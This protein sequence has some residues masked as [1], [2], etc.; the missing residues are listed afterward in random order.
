MKT[1]IINK[2]HRL[3]V[4]CKT[5]MENAIQF[6]FLTSPFKNT[7][8]IILLLLL[9]SLNAQAQYPCNTFVKQVDGIGTTE[10]RIFK[11]PSISNYYITAT[12]NDTIFIS[13]VNASGTVLST[14]IV[15]IS[16]DFV[17]VTDMIIDR[18]DGTLAAIVRGNNANYMFRYNYG[19][20]SL[21][22][23]QKYT[24]S[25]IFLNI[26]QLSTTGNYIVTGEVL[27]GGHT[28]FQVN[29][30]TGAMIT[31]QK[32]GF[33]GDF[34]SA[35]DGNDIYGACRYYSSGSLFNPS[36][37]R[38]DPS[39]GNNIWT[40]TYIVNP[41]STTCRIY[42]VAP[43][44][45]QTDVVQLSSGDDVTFNTYQTGPTNAWLLKTD[46]A[47]TLAWTNQITIPGYTQLN[48]KKILN[49]ANGYYLLIDSY[50]GGTGVLDYFFVIMTD[51]NGNLQWCN[52]YGIT[53]INSVIGGIEDNGY[54]LLT[55]VSGSFAPG[56]NLVFLKL[57]PNGMSDVNC[58][59]IRQMSCNIQPYNNTQAPKP[60]PMV[61][62]GY[63]NSPMGAPLY[64]T[65]PIE[66]IYC[67]TSCTSILPCSTLTG[68]LASGVMAFWPFGNGSLLDL[69]GNGHTLNNSTFAY[70][71]GDRSGNTNCAYHFTRANPDFLDISSASGTAFLNSITTSAFSIS[72]W[73]QPT[74]STRGVGD[75]ELLIGRGATPLHCPDTWG[76][77]SVGL[78]DCRKAVVGFDQYSHWQGSTYP[79]CN[80]QMAAFTNS[81]HHLAFT[82]DGVSTYNLYIDGTLY[83]TSSGPCGS[84]SANIGP[85]KLGEDYDGDLDDVIIYN[86]AI[87]AAEVT[88]LMAL[89]GS[90]CDGVS[91]SYRPG[92]PAQ[93]TG[94]K[95]EGIKIYPN[96]TNGQVSVT[97][98]NSIIR[99][100]IVYN[101]IGV[102]V[103]TYDFNAP[104]ASINLGSL[105]PGIYSIKVITDNGST[106]E[107]VTK[108]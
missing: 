96:P 95:L 98:G 51:K 43:I 64:K 57:D 47:G 85:L 28:I 100:I 67:S 70:S 25:Y 103:G 16:G 14:Q 76:E 20:A 13:N 34:Y 75:Y 79:T 8:T 38:F 37:F 31:Y 17:S 12:H 10:P 21:V 105:I 36:L 104:K 74:T 82:Y 86:R 94:K 50:N 3:S 52:R 87:T 88:A 77:W 72:L 29:R 19:S 91:S 7:L 32:S 49:T 65:K 59:Y 56:S 73:Y 66:T 80:A 102:T 27:L 23:L 39:T 71:T 41:P 55:A 83:S 2:P 22:W 99:T 45:D 4:I 15:V 24:P 93:N 106:I 44:V 89:N 30:G 78:Y 108:E 42:P 60:D 46:L 54:L 81:W 92:S 53:G 26:H 33:T 9:V 68:S 69:S 107:K 84:M 18:I 97:A 61:N 1:S 62:T 35:Y 40:N 58:R 101:N 5:K 63:T 48:V 6:S 11:D 90:C